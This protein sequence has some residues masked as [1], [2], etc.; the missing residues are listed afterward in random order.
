MS[1]TNKKRTLNEETAVSKAVLHFQ[2]EDLATSVTPIMKQKISESYRR[3][4]LKP[5]KPQRALNLKFFQI[6]NKLKPIN[7]KNDIDQ[8]IHHLANTVDEQKIEH[9]SL[10]NEVNHIQTEC[11][12]LPPRTR[13]LTVQT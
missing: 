4:W 3:K 7:L 9:K 12:K 8:T 1:Q 6:G 11:A 2:L 10:E 5:Q 13:S